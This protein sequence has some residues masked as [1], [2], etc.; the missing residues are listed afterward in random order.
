MT[1]GVFW[2]WAI[3]IAALANLISP[4]HGRAVL[5]LAASI[6]PPTNPVREG[7]SVVTGTLYGLVDGAVS[8]AV[9]DCLYNLFANRRSGA[10]QPSTRTAQRDKQPW[11]ALCHLRRVLTAEMQRMD[12]ATLARPSSFGMRWARIDDPRRRLSGSRPCLPKLAQVCARCGW[13]E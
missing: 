13:V 7:V 5:E 12:E 9:F 6:Y 8:D 2:G 4:T 10:V 11:Q 3:L 1:V